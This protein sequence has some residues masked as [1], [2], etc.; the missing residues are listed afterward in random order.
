[1]T[2]LPAGEI[3]LKPDLKS[4]STGSRRRCLARSPSS[5]ARAATLTLDGKGY[6]GELRVT[7]V[8]EG[9]AGHRRRRPRRVPPRRRPRRDAEGVARR[10]A[11][12]PGGRRPL[13]RAREHRQEPRLRPLLR[14]AQ[15]GVL[16]RRGGVAG[17]DRGREGDEGR[18]PHLRRQGRDDVLLLVLRRPH[19]LERGRLRD[20]HAL[21]PG[22]RRSLG[23]ALA[24]PPLGARSFT[25]AS[26]AQAFGLSAPVVDVEVVPTASGR[27]ASVTLVKKTGAR[28]LL[29][30]ADVRARLGLAL[31]GV[32]AR[33]PAR[34]P[35]AAPRCRRERRSSSPASPATSTA[36]CS[37]SSARA[38]PGF[39]RSRS[40]PRRTAPSPSRCGR[41]P[42]RPTG[43]RPTARSGRR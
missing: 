33:R 3:A 9:S 5:P 20:R 24:V 37:R 18:D 26:L 22:P 7:V 4:S 40:C 23:H 8:A 43:S 17:D 36:R 10:G 30:A 39:R 25:A 15:P 41:R 34:R 42:P 13:L 12:G 11:P 29:A 35:P 32:P 1:M 16:R 28:V 19:G 21:P 14:P 2:P 27:P 6:R 38:A 31:D